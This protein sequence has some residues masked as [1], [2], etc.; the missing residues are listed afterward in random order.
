MQDAHTGSWARGTQVPLELLESVRDLNRRFLDLAAGE[1]GGWRSAGRVMPADLSARLAPLSPGQK[2]AAANCPYALFDLNF[3]DDEHWRT[4][5]RNAGSWGV[6]ESSAVDAAA[7]GPAVD[8]PTL[9][10]VKVALFFAWH[11]SSAARL[12]PQLLLGMHDA[13]ATAFRSA[14]IDCL[15]SLA[16]TEATHLTARWNECA[17]YWSALTSAASRPD[18]TELRR[19]QLYGLQ[20]AAAARLA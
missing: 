20:L 6:S 19:I 15:P 11:V 13:T 4:R 8:A 14:T 2:N 5:L 16:A 18:S 12:A 7:P 10:F 1:T 9:E 17:R 3:D